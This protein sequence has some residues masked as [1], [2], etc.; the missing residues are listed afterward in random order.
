MIV[1]DF[2][3]PEDTHPECVVALIHEMVEPSLL[4]VEPD[5]NRGH[6]LRMERLALVEELDH[7]C[8][9]LAAYALN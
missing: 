2:R 3:Y 4:K 6:Y 9:E 1:L 8:L 7:M 5:R